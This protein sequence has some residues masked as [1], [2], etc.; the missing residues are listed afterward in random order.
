MKQLYAELVK[1]GVDLKLVKMEN[2]HFTLKFLGN[3]SEERISVI[4]ESITAALL[5]QK[6]FSLSLRGMGTFSNKDRITVVWIGVVD[7]PLALLMKKISQKLE[8][9]RKKEGEDAPHLTIARVKSGKNPQWLKEIISEYKF[10]EFGTMVVE[11][12]V[13]YESE[14]GKEGAKYRVVR[15]FSLE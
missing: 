9:E 10:K 1:K 14:L 7:S 8:F 2:L 15:E 5:G 12:V 4:E 11:K 6:S 13:L 3:I